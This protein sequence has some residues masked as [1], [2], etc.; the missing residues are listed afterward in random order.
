MEDKQAWI[1]RYVGGRL[2][3]HMEA[4]YG[5]REEAEERGMKCADSE[6][7]GSGYVVI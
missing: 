4:F 3:G 5:T 2:H 7:T 6:N 1:I